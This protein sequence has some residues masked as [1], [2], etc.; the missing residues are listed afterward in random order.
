MIIKESKYITKEDYMNV[1]R[2]LSSELL[3]LSEL[4]ENV[5]RDWETVTLDPGINYELENMMEDF[6]N[7]KCLIE[8]YDENVGKMLG[9]F[10]ELCYQL[11]EDMLDEE[12]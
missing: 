10:S 4:Y 6:P 7:M 12:E 8:M 1:L 5:V 9:N 2:T 11:S 3:D